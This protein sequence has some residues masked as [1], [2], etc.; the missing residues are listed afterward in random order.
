M[1]E[2]LRQP[3][4]RFFRHE[5]AS[6][7]LLLLATIAAL[8]MANTGLAEIY[9]RSLHT[10][11]SFGIGNQS[12]S[13]ELHHWINDGLMVI[14]FFVIGLE[15]KRELIAGEL[16]S[17]SKAG[18][19]FIAAIGGVA[20]P[21]ITF[22]LINDNPET[23]TGWAIPMA[24]DIAFSIGILK[25]LGKAVPY[26]IK[27]FLVAF[28]IVDDLIAVVT[29]AIFYT[30]QIQ[31]ELVGAALAIVAVLMLMSRFNL[32]QRHFYLAIG[33]LVWYLFLQSG[34]HATIAGVLMA[35]TI[36]IRRKARLADIQA[37][38]QGE[39][40]Q[41]KDCKPGKSLLSHP[42]LHALDAIELLS[43]NAAS[44][45]QYLENKL[46][47]IVAFVIMP[48]FAFANAGVNL[49]NFESAPLN[50]SLAIG[51]GLLLGKVMGISLFAWLGLR[52]RLVSL[53]EGI[54]FKHVM[55]VSILG[56]VGF[57]MSLFFTNLAF[58]QPEFIDASKLGILAGSLL[59][60]IIGYL[61][62]KRSLK[63]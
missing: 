14:F 22:L 55:A 8:I 32:Y 56:G 45:L 42:Q 6:S 59:A 28:A 9:F 23:R 40:N 2:I 34:V 52:F 15:I 29:I 54:R 7:V 19:P 46:H 44:P 41:L 51:L 13:K 3:F 27:V 37:G 25:L 62:V 16:S 48:V 26:S 49:G 61:A 47:T 53:P 57:T 21:I 11:L 30:E 18:L 4:E 38:I 63:Q 35:L 39:L 20:I 31:L 10:P 5:S 58:S 17:V 36:P 50:L 1:T 33:I 24:T 12:L 60:G 43:K